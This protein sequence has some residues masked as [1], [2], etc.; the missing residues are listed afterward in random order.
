M[1]FDIHQEDGVVLEYEKALPQ[2]LHRY[3][4]TTN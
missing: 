2:T 3:N 4:R 1:N